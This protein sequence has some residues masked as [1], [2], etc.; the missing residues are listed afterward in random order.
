MY[1][2]ILTPLGQQLYPRK[3]GGGHGG[4]GGKGGGEGGGKSG[5][6]SGSSGSK[7]APRSVS[8]PGSTG[9]K[10]TA[11]SYGGGGGR[12]TTIPAGQVF[13]GRSSGGGTRNEVFGTS[14]YGSGYPGVTGRGVAGRGFPFI[15]WPLVWGEGLGYG[16]NYLFGSE[17]GTPNNSSRPGGPMAEGTFAS[18]TSNNTF[19]VLSDNTTVSELIT[20]ISSNCTLGSSSSSSPSPFNGSASEPRPEQ[21]VQY[22]RASSVVLTLDGYNDTG[23]LGNDPNATATPLPGWV[24]TTLLDC[25][26]QTIGAAVPLISGADGRWHTPSMGLLG[27]VYMLWTLSSLV[28]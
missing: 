6:S 9:G 5:S 8:I 21:A 20:S 15:F 1:V 28:I 18:N 4:G 23:V 11:V 24:D 26:N 25:L 22:Y 3:G 19:H 10:Q 14:Q 27:L 7:G 2:P 16:A 17:Y 13:A 12:V